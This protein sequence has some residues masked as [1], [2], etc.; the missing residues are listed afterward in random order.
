MHNKSSLKSW[1]P[2]GVQLFGPSIYEGPAIRLIK[3]KFW[4]IFIELSNFNGFCD[5][6]NK[7]QHWLS[8]IAK[9]IQFQWFPQFKKQFSTLASAHCK[10]NP[11]SVVSVISKTNTNIGFRSLRKQFEFFL[12]LYY[13]HEVSILLTCSLLIHKS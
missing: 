3:Q 2:S 9:A 12:G 6:R 10:S 8:L 11:I 1:S 5:S 7:Y 13:F 4:I